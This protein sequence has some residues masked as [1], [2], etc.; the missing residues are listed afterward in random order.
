MLCNDLL[1]TRMKKRRQRTWV[2]VK[3]VLKVEVA[4]SCMLNGRCVRATQCP[5]AR[6]GIPQL[7][8]I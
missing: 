8:Q 1:R 6:I 3:F 2:K 4:A 5:I 7:L